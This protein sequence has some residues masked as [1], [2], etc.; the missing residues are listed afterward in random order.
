LSKRTKNSLLR[1]S[2]TALAA[3]WD[4]M[5]R[6]SCAQ[7]PADRHAQPID[8]SPITASIRRRM[9]SPASIET[10]SPRER[11]LVQCR[12]FPV[13]STAMPAMEA[14]MP[15]MEVE[16]VETMEVVE[17]M[18]SRKPRP[19]AV[20]PFRPWLIAVA[21]CTDRCTGRKAYQHDDCCREDCQ[22]THAIQMVSPRS[23]DKISERRRASYQSL[24]GASGRR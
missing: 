5:T 7:A 17:M 16:A 10:R 19:A 12:G 15:T 13:R 6:T 20:I 23:G 18:E 9:I 21:R 2:T 3:G 22:P 1:P 8:V 24:P 14:T 11:R 4:C